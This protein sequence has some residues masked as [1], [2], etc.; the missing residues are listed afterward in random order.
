MRQ[1]VG[2][3][4]VGMDTELF[5][6]REVAQHPC[7]VQRLLPRL[8]LLRV[9]IILLV[10]AEAPAAG[11][12]GVCVLQCEEV[13]P[14]DPPPLVAV[15]S[16]YAVQK[17]A[18]PLPVQVVG[19]VSR[20]PAVQ[21]HLVRH[22]AAAGKEVVEVLSRGDGLHEVTHNH[23][24][25]SLV[26]YSVVHLKCSSRGL[27]ALILMYPRRAVSSSSGISSS[28]ISAGV[29]PLT[30]VPPVMPKRRRIAACACRSP[31][32]QYTVSFILPFLLV[33]LP[34]FPPA[35]TAGRTFP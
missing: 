9:E 19:E 12:V 16:V 32:A 26:G 2:A 10:V 14:A 13:L 35:G 34:L 5:H 6:R 8:Y 31:V 1:D 20:E 11:H 18:Q 29:S 33:L 15:L 28:L 7:I 23:V 17:E 22:G 3:A 25:A 21:Q 27:Y 24:L 30:V 4:A